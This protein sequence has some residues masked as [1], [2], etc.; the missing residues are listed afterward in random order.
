[1][2][3]RFAYLIQCFIKYIL[4]KRQEKESCLV[5]PQWSEYFYIKKKKDHIRLDLN[6]KFKIQ[7]IVYTYTDLFL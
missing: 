4:N 7:V 5:V 2:N 1:M 3:A 6:L